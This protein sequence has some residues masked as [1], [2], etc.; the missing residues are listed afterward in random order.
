MAPGPDDLDMVAYG[1]T[2]TVDVA[3]TSAGLAG[4]LLVGRPGTFSGSSKS[5]ANS[6]SGGGGAP[7]AEAGGSGA[8][9]IEVVPLLVTIQK[10]G[11]S[12]LIVA[13]LAAAGLEGVDTESESFQEAGMKHTLNVSTRPSTAR[14]PATWRRGAGACWP[15][16]GFPREPGARSRAP[17]CRRPIARRQPT[18]TPCPPPLPFALAGVHVLQRTRAALCPW[19]DYALCYAGPGI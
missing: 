9:S 6:S 5:S 3:H 14:C 4:M 1:Y 11:Q 8:S 12:P 18:Q 16:A 15:S 19:V 7:A 17:V 13:S 10:E 2:S